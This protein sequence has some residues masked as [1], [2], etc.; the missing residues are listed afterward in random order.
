MREIRTMIDDAAGKDAIF[1]HSFL[2]KHILP[3][4]SRDQFSN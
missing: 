1:L 3:L 4:I 2:N